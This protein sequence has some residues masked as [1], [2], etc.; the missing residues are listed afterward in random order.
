MITGDAVRI[1]VNNSHDIASR[2]PLA[3]RRGYGVRTMAAHIT[4]ILRY[5]VKG[6]NSE[7][8]DATTLS[9]GGGIPNDRR[10]AMAPTSSRFDSEHPA[11]CAK[12]EFLMLMKDERLALLAARF[13]DATSVLTINRDGKQVA[14]GDV[15]TPM[16]RVLIEQFL[17]AFMPTGPRGNPKI[18]TAP[19]T[20]FTDCETPFISII[21]LASVRDIERVARRT[22]DPFRF[23]GNLHIDGLE[24]WAETDWIGHTCKIGD[25]VLRIAEP[26]GRCAATSVN[27]ETAER[28]MNILLAL[29]QGFGHTQTGVYAE[30]LEGGAI[31]VNDALTLG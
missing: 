27:P 9:V 17:A 19:G 12:N 26:T 7:R 18:V 5:P 28:D 10:F 15:S 31:G 11:W 13:D 16:G 29:K 6:L 22:V 30:V 25:A 24:P 2:V 20:M 23:R 8:L 14:R 4:D 3:K 21:N 1:K